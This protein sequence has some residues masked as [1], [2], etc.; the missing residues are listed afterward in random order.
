MKGFKEY[1][2]EKKDDA[3]SLTLLAIAHGIDKTI[4]Y[5]VPRDLAIE[6]VTDMAKNGRKDF[7]INVK[8]LQPYYVSATNSE[9]ETTAEEAEN[10]ESEADFWVDL[11]DP[12]VSAQEAL[13]Q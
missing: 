10:M 8:K 6:F 11:D 1:C 12:K 5:D 13:E 4:I 7:N 2:N 9:N 3:K